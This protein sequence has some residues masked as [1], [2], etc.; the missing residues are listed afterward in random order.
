M[1]KITK[2][3]KTQKLNEPQSGPVPLHCLSKLVDE[4]LV[5]SLSFLIEKFPLPPNKSCSR[6]TQNG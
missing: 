4:K 1:K 6:Y 3:K 2:E 5:I